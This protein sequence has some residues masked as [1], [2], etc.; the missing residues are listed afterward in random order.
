MK[1]LCCSFLLLLSAGLSANTVELDKVA[2]IVD[3]GVV[4]ESEINEML[5]GVKR[6]ALKSGQELPSERALRT[7][8]IE[9]LILTNLQLQMAE[10][11]GIQISDPQLEQTIANIAQGDGMSK[12][13]L[14]EKLTKEGVSYD[15]YR[16]EVRRELI[17]GEVRRANVRRRVYIT[18]QEVESLVSLME[19][20]GMQ[21]AEYHLGHIL[22]GFPAQPTD[23]D[24]DATRE[25]A[26]KVIELLNGGSDF[27]KIAIAS[28]SGAKAL[29]GGDMGWMNINAMPTL[30]AE[31]V[32]GKKKGDLIGPIR[33]GA[34]FHIL[35]IFDTRGLQTVEVTEVNSRHILIK[36]SVILSEEK[37]EQML[38]DFRE[39]LIKGEADFAKLA[40]DNSA[41]PGSALKG[42][43]LGW[44][45]PTI[46]VPA[47]RDI[48]NNLEKDEYS[49]PFRSQLGWHL[50]Q[51]L[52][53]RVG[54]ATEKLQEDK[55][56]QLLFSRKF[57]EEADN[58]MREMRD[59]A[60]IEV[61]E[62]Q[63]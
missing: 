39:K 16:E 23:A 42:G 29:E 21:Q 14:R 22:I 40:K 51:L 26:D 61:L 52:D 11:M 20:Q 7:Q 48:L 55:A 2:V 47:F 12:E 54:D 1:F 15:S 34:G 10:R 38:K 58:W 17:M 37:A 13:Q 31:A 43:E 35:T 6:N 25:R 33:S 45:D 59:Q 50:V 30:F 18:P 62:Q 3:Q 24:I 63:Q 53:R 8:V 32:Q 36:P 19:E 46:Y 49:Q 41:D 44:A 56:Y 28:S 4:L 57:A 27:S 60:Y 9:R 5:E